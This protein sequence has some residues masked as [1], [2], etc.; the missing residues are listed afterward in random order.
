[1]PDG[2]IS[3]SA[4]GAITPGAT[5]TFLVDVPAGYPAI[6]SV[7]A[8]FAQGEAPAT[9]LASTSSLRSA[10]RY[11]VAVAVPATLP[12]GARVF[13]RLIHAD[14]AVVESGIEDFLVP[15]R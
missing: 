13:V 11:A 15:G 14:G 12:A 7:E 3:V 9:S 10:G 6:A 5:A 1:M 4:E 8:G 2:S